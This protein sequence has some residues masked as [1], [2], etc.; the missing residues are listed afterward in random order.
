MDIYSLN[1][2]IKIILGI[3]GLLFFCLGFLSFESEQTRLKDKLEDWWIRLDDKNKITNKKYIEFIRRI[4]S[5]TTFIINKVFGEKIFSFQSAWVSVFYL[6]SMILLIGL[7]FTPLKDS[8][9]YNE[10]YYIWLT[11]G[12]IYA[13]LAILPLII[14]SKIWIKWGCLSVSILYIII[15]IAILILSDK[16]FSFDRI[17]LISTKGLW[18]CNTIGVPIGVILCM[19]LIGF[20]RWS[21]QKCSDFTSL[22]NIVISI[23]ISLIIAFITI[24]LPFGISNIIL[25][26]YITEY[27]VVTFPEY[28]SI[29]LIIFSAFN[30]ISLFPLLLF[31]ILLITIPLNNF[32]WSLL[33]RS[34]YNFTQYKIIANKSILYTLCVLFITLSFRLT[35]LP[36]YSSKYITGDVWSTNMNIYVWFEWGTTSNYGNTS[37]IYSFYNGKHHIKYKLTNLNSDTKYYYRLMLKNDEGIVKNGGEKTF[38]TTHNYE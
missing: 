25:S 38:I 8:L 11:I 10:I 12:F 14:K 19:S 13:F 4:S 23:S 2:I 9:P 21:I 27:N 35:I 22:K 32:I 15:F 31:I 37:P 3:V 17:H 7:F 1:T 29:L 16:W 6:H 30:L 36:D 26:S 20:F 24:I 5:L 28:V 34:I 18:Y 33:S